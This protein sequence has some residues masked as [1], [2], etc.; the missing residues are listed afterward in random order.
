M[1]HAG[2]SI[3]GRRL[4]GCL[5]DKNLTRITRR[6]VSKYAYTYAF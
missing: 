4:L 6:G 2:V 3:V 1:A 5:Y